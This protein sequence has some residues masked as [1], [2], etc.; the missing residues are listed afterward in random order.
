MADRAGINVFF[1]LF[2]REGGVSGSSIIPQ[3]RIQIN[4]SS[5]GA[6]NF[7]GCKDN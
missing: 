1:T 5:L 2:Y 4:Q 3:I 6:V 7:L